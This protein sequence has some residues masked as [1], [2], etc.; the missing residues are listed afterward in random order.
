MIHFSFRQFAT[1]KSLNFIADKCW[2]LEKW[3]KQIE[4]VHNFKLNI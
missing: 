1:D 2:L 3:Q 4:K